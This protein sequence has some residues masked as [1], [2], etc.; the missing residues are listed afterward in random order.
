MNAA[1]KTLIVCLVLATALA[2]APGALAAGG[3]ERSDTPA[4]DPSSDAPSAIDQYLEVVPGPEG[5][6][7]P[8]EFSRSLGG[9]GGPVTRAQIVAAARANSARR[10]R[11]AAQG[12]LSPETGISYSAG[13][14]P[15]GTLA[16]FTNAATSGAGSSGLWLPL[17]AIALATVAL[18]LIVRRRTN[19]SVY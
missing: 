2:A 3:G 18:A 1:F 16:A 8:E 14:E 6:Q 17:L 11:D 9:D 5:G 10:A 19:Q 15:P 13:E 4:A 12:R 7:T